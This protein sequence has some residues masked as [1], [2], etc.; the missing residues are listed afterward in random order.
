MKLAIL[1]VEHKRSALDD[2]IDEYVKKIMGFVTAE[3]ILVRVSKYARDDHA[4]KL[5]GESQELLKKIELTDY[6]I[7]FDEH[8][9]QHSS[10]QFSKRLGA[11]FES[12]KRRVVFVIGGAYGMS[13]EL[14][15]RGQETWS[16]STLTFAHPIALVTGLEQ[17]YRALT[18]WKNI[19]YHNQNNHK[20]LAVNSCRR[21]T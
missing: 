17:I 21:K 6:V 18:I 14:K 1:S 12:G 5:A 10:L 16:L 20:P 2:V 4:K 9:Q 7:L 13:P 3:M 8:G 11:A 19:P 15:Q